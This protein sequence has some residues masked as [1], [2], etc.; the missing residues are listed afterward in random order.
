MIN[1]TSSIIL[2]QLSSKTILKSTPCVYKPRRDLPPRIKLSIYWYHWDLEA[3]LVK[4]SKV[5]LGVSERALR[6]SQ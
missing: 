4:P 6:V 2:S 3:K 1:Y 5:A